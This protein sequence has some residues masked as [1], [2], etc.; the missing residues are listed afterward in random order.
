M[1]R[2]G[3]V[4]L[5]MQQTVEGLS[6]AAITYYGAGLIGYLAKP[7]KSVWPALNPDWVVA[8]AIPLLAFGVWRAVGRIRRELMRD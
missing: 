2:R 4:S 7:L 8:A 5:R 3:K 6:V 1:E